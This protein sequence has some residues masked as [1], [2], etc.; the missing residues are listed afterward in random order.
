CAALPEALLES[1]LFGHERGAFTGADQRRIGKFEQVHG[2]TILLDEI[3]DM[4]PA[5]QAKALRLL[6]RQEFERVGGSTTISTD[7]RI[8]AATNHNLP[9]LVEEGKFR[10]DLYYR[11]S[12]FT[13]Q[14]PALRDRKE[15]L[16]QLTEHFIRQLNRELGKRIR[17]LTPEASAA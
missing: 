7:V 3:G 15:D 16:P 12:G 8:V 9:T 6:Q 14:L 11:L 4:S 2:G 13:I 5:T 1:E 17:T 10:Q